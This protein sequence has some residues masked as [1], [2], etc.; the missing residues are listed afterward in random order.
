MHL[1]AN[2]TFTFPN[3]SPSLCSQLPSGSCPAPQASLQPRSKPSRHTNLLAVGPSGRHMFFLS[4]EP[5]HMQFHLLAHPFLS[6]LTQL[7]ITS[8][9][10]PSLILIPW[11]TVV[12]DAWEVIHSLDGGSEEEGGSWDS[13]WTS[14]KGPGG[15]LCHFL[16]V[17]RINSGWDWVPL[18]TSGHPGQASRRTLGI[19]GLELMRVGAGESW[20]HEHRGGSFVQKRRKASSGSWGVG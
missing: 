8:S 5:L 6:A 9:R 16:V 3:S 4:S 7:S 2:L 18:T 11:G 19:W 13:L 12:R 20:S 10:K 17:E 14:H 15:W 1:K